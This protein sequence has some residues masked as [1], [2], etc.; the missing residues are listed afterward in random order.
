L[1]GGKVPIGYVI[2][3]YEFD[4]LLFR[5]AVK[6][7]AHDLSG[8]EF[9][10]ATFDDN[11]RSW[12]LNL[13]RGGEPIIVKAKYVVGADGPRSKVR[14][15]LGQPFND[16]EHTGTA[17]RVYCRTSDVF[18][19]ELRLDF[20][21]SLLPAYGWVFPIDEH[22][23]NIGVG[24]DVSRYQERKRH[25]NVLLS[26][27]LGLQRAVESD[28]QTRLAFILPYGSQLP[29]LGF[30][31]KQAA[32]VGDAGSMVN[33]LTG[34]GIFYGMWAGSEVAKHIARA[35]QTNAPSNLKRYE[36]LFRSKFEDHYKTNQIMKRRVA[37]P[38][39]CDFVLSACAR[40]K[41]ILGELIDLMMGDRKH[42]S[43]ALLGK[44]A[45]SGRL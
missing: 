6:A 40:D 45:L 5:A 7:G 16:D 4:E 39:W 34:E 27:Y 44:I 10:D 23:A 28:E 22:T 30:P 1:V 14:R 15:L 31:E 38:V 3:R 8:C 21:R 37:H 43:F 2:K 25:L 41:R 12:T 13:V 18:K 24:I 17:V 9:K 11:A 26:E 19:K 42:L 29:Q 35:L 33:P 20:M 36:V 32:L